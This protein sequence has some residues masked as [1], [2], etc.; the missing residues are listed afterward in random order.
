MVPSPVSVEVAEDTLRTLK[1][2][3]PKAGR[4]LILR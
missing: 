1:G 2:S 3:P 4:H